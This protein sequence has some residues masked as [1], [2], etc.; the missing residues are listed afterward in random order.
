MVSENHALLHYDSPYLHGTLRIYPTKQP[1]AKKDVRLQ[2][3][4]GREVPIPL[5]PE[6]AS[7]ITHL[8]NT[9]V[10]ID[11]ESQQRPIIYKLESYDPDTCVKTF[12]SVILPSV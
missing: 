6:E 10:K 4:T 5:Y 12:V 3:N 2:L 11:L 9:E 8:V 7:A 1:Y